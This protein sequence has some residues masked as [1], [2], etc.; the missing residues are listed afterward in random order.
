LRN[1]ISTLEQTIKDKQAIIDAYEAQGPNS[2]I[3]KEQYDAAIK[4]KKDAEEKLAKEQSAHKVTQDK[5]D[6]ANKTI[7][8]LNTEISDLRTSL[9]IYKSTHS[10]SDTEYEALQDAFE[11]LQDRY[12]ILR[13]QL[14]NAVTQ[15]EYDAALANLAKFQT[16]ANRAYE[17]FYGVSGECTPEQLAAIL[18][19]FGFDV[20]QNTGDPSNNIYQPGR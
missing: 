1:K 10:Y 20:Q 16:L 11:D 14:Q 15:E 5:L 6:K 3:T 2:G 17:L 18:E 9:E 13:E 12:D 7:A 8:N 4:A 19:Q